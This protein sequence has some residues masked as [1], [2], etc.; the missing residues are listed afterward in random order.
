MSS[1]DIVAMTPIPLGSTQ[2]IPQIRFLRRGIQGHPRVD[3]RIPVEA[4]R[5]MC[6]PLQTVFERCRFSFLLQGRAQDR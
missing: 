2:F 5:P 3:F 1:L 4:G 6:I